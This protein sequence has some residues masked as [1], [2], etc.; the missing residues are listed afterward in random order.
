MAKISGWAYVIVGVAVAIYS[1]FVE[2][3]RP[4]VALTIFFWIGVALIAVGVFRLVLAF[5]AGE[6]DKL[7]A[8]PDAPQGRRARN[9]A[10]RPAYARDYIVC[11]RCNARLHPQS[12]YC[13]WCGTQQ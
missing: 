10:E 5:I 4:G 11:P 7:R 9:E 8:K 2:A 1:K 3:R 6:K 12:R 13:N